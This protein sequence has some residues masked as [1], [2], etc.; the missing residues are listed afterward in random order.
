MRLCLSGKSL[1]YL[2]LKVFALLVYFKSSN[3]PRDAVNM[4]GDIDRCG[5]FL[6]GNQTH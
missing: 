5:S 2:L 6:I 3:D 4:A 1:R